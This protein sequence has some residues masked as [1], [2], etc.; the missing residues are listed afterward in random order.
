MRII[1]GSYLPYRRFVQ[2][3][4]TS[5][6]YR[7]NPLKVCFESILPE[8]GLCAGLI[9]STFE[10]V[11]DT[12]GVA[13]EFMERAFESFGEPEEVKHLGSDANMVIMRARGGFAD[14][15][16]LR[17]RHCPAKGMLQEGR[18]GS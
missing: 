6:A 11:P 15:V 16:V 13:P 14:A 17:Q 10:D 5:D 7:P 18:T 8:I 3:R 2:I 12:I 9:V 1:P 4:K